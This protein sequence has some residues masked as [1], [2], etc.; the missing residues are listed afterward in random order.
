MPDHRRG[1]TQRKKG[2]LPSDPKMA[3]N[4]E[5]RAKRNETTFDDQLS[6]ALLEELIASCPKISCRLHG[7]SVELTHVH[8]LVSWK[9]V[10]GWMSVR[11][12]LKASLTKRLKTMGDDV[13]LSRGG[14][15]KH[16]EDRDHF[17]YLM[18]TYLP[19]HEGIA[20]YEDRRWL[21]QRGKK[22]R[23]K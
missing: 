20:W 19:R 13:S 21:V 22:K 9:H 18:Q 12:S 5:R 10:R 4:Y 17:E 23:K 6:R 7:G 8:A 14:S 16:V 2:Y 15:R 11:T 3:R 1:Y